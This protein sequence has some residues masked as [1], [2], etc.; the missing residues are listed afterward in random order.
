[1]KRLFKLAINLVAGLAAGL[2]L[3]VPA[4][5]VQNPQ[6]GSIGLETT[7]TT[8][9]PSRP[10]GITIPQN[11]ANFSTSTITVSGTC[12]GAV[13]V[14]VFSNNVFVGSVPCKNNTY[15][16][17]I[18]L[19]TGTN[20]LITRVYDALDQA[21]PD[22]NTVVVVFNG[23]RLDEQVNQI[24][25]TSSFAL[26]GAPPDTELTWPIA[27]SGGKG[28]YAISVDWGDGSPSDLLSQQSAGDFNIKHIFKT[29]GLYK[30]I[31]KA[32]DSNTDTAFLQL[33]GQATGA[34]QSSAVSGTG[35]TGG[36]LPKAGGWWAG[37]AM[38]PLIIL[39]FWAGRR[40]KL[41]SLQK[42]VEKTRGA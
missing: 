23:S 37:A 13:L 27:L 20:E 41:L 25:L 29:A 12:P 16:L 9:P 26:R 4:Y 33:T 39:A 38:L 24:Y 14:K 19:F 2:L 6:S 11:G 35:T 17:Q 10:G 1:M 34:L 15:S 22:S 31:V 3:A 18:D 21:G 40:Q 7:I 42:Q 30:I 36:N 32:S 8:T 5:A 28:P